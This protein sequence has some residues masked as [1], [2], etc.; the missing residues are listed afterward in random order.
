MFKDKKIIC[1]IPARG[2]SKGI[3]MKNIYPFLDK[4]LIYYTIEFAKKVKFIDRILVSSDSDEIVRYSKS[5]G[6][7][8][9][10]L[11]PVVLSGDYISDKE[12]I[13][14]ILIDF[15]D[16]SKINIDC[17]L[18]L[19]PTSPI[20][21]IEDFEM[22]FKR[23]FSENLDSLWTISEVDSKF[24]PLKQLIIN[25]DN[26]IE[27]FDETGRVVTARQQLAKTYI[28][29]GVAYLFKP[30]FILSNQKLLPKKTG[31][32]LINY[33]VVS[34]DSIKDFNNAEILYKEL[35]NE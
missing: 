7:D 28:R 35:N 8:F 22:M 19:Q 30:D 10:Y 1:V 15:M 3:K 2:G 23:F 25:L 16:K 6:L 33:P 29:N 31:Y 34:I 9:D 13:K 18:Y 24:H 27:L 32:Y 14:D 5:L 11:R 26:F 4:P 21:K 17:V 20:R 12:V